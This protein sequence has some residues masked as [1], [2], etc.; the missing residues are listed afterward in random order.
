MA[1]E[2]DKANDHAEMMLAKQVEAAR[3][4]HKAIEETGKCLFCDEDLE[5]GKRWCDE[6]CRDDWQRLED[7]K[8]RNKNV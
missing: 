7:S 1:D 4:I 6:G 8:R 2:I 5:K 3:Q